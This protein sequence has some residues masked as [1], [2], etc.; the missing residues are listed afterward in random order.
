VINAVLQLSLA[1]IPHLE[2]WSGSNMAKKRH[3][4][5]DAVRC[6]LITELELIRVGRLR[7]I[8]RGDAY[9]TRPIWTVD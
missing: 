5:E 1:H 4:V 2:V 8:Y 9:F 6:T 7:V 3:E